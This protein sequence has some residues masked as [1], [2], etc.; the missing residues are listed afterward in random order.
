MSGPMGTVLTPPQVP[1]VMADVSIPPEE[2]V[3]EVFCTF[4]DSSGV[5]HARRYPVYSWCRSA[6][7]WIMLPFE[8]P[9]VLQLDERCCLTRHDARAG[10]L[11][12]MVDNSDRDDPTGGGR[13]G[14]EHP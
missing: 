10:A 4:S 1:H 8:H 7:P 5:S 2:N 14:C 6:P 13:N 11:F 3:E 9:C 12:R